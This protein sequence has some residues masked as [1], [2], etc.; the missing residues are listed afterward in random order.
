M[1]SQPKESRGAVL[2]DWPLQ[3]RVWLD[4]V[5]DG[6][7]IMTAD[8]WAGVVDALP[9][10]RQGSYQIQESDQSVVAVAI[11]NGDGTC[12]MQWGRKRG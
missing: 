9:E 10:M 12:R 11:S 7:I 8:G 6:R 5:K 3:R 4:I 2:E 1:H